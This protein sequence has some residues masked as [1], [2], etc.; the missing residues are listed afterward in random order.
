MELKRE[1]LQSLISLI[2]DFSS[3]NVIIVEGAR[4]VGKTT[5][6]NQALGQLKKKVRNH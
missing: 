4:Q 1:S 3:K 2:K 5:L 6:I